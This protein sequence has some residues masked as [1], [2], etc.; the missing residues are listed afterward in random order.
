[1]LA[2]YCAHGHKEYK[3]TIALT[4][5]QVEEIIIIAVCSRGETAPSAKARRRVAAVLN[6]TVA[7]AEKRNVL[8]HQA[9]L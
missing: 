2:F 5:P 8:C 6:G 7:A 3:N 9:S 4:S 1:M